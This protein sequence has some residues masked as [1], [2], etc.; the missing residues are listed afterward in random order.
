MSLMESVPA[1]TLAA[2]QRFLLYDVS[3]Q[4]PERFLAEMGGRRLFLTYDRGT[5]ELMSP[6]T[7][8]GRST[9]ILGWAILILAEELEIPIDILGM[10]T[11]RREDRGKGLEPDDCFYLRHEPLVRE[12]EEIDLMVDPPPDLAIE[13]K[14]SRSA[15]DKLAIYAGLGF[16]EVWRNDGATIH[17]YVPQAD[18]PYAIRESSPNFP[19]LPMAEL[20]RFLHMA[21]TMDKT[22]WARA[23]RGWVRDEIL[24]RVREA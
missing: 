8:H 22:S 16:P 1:S 17:V 4:F 9:S 6:S 7:V 11:F 20:L 19:F 3:W 5:L 18:G 23:F 14:V 13:V 15:L 2:D 21:A 24:P 12:K 10:V